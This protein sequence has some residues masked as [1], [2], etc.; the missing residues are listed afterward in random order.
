[1]P[2]TTSDAPDARSSRA[3]ALVAGGILISRIIGLVRQRV[4]SHYFGLSTDAA[5]AWAAG[6]RIPNLLQN[7]F[8]EG[9]LSASFIPVYSGLRS[10]QRT[11]EADAVAAMVG[12]WLAM[13]VSLGVALGVLLTPWAISLIAPGFTGDKRALTIS[14]VRILFPGAGLLVM[15]AWCLGIL[16]SHRQF[17]LSYA[18]PVAWSL[19]M[20]GAMLWYGPGAE[21][22][23]LVLILAWASV[24][25]SLLQFLVQLPVVWKIAPGMRRLD[26]GQD[27]ARLVVRNF[28]PTMMSRGVVQ[29][30]SYIDT[31]IASFLPLGAAAALTNAQTLYSLP[32]SLF[33]ISVSASELPAMSAVA[34]GESAYERLRERLNHSQRRV[35]FFVV[36]SAVAFLAFGDVIAAALFQTGRFSATDAVWIWGILAGSAIG[37]LASTLARL[38]SSTFFALRDTRSPLKFAAVRVACSTALGYVGAFH[39]PRL[40]QIAPEWGTAGLT[41]AGGLAGWLEFWLLRRALS[42]RVGPVGISLAYVTRLWVCGIAGALVGWALKLVVDGWPPLIVAPLVLAPFGAAYVASAL[43]LGV[44]DALPRRVT[45]ALRL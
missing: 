26:G 16:N 44:A 42:R 45:R 39:L 33:G 36:P 12:L 21:L 18:S 43:L 8:G 17:F 3:A 4:I 7:L 2:T 15:S 1:V 11:R 34:A 9:A 31:M 27:E 19:V 10:Q 41:V 32:V 14:V 35:A 30:S 38:Y 28:L 22:P 6:F 37:L 25:G 5:D 40:L 24:A 29:I 20:I 23:R 13:A